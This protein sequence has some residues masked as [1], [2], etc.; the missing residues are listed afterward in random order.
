MRFVTLAARHHAMLLYMGI[1]LES[2]G[3]LDQVIKRHRLAVSISMARLVQTGFLEN[4]ADGR[5]QRGET[6]F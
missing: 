4:E 1:S 3:L 2:R 6:A 5:L